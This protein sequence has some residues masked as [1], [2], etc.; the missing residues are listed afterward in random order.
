[1]NFVEFD[2]DE[3]IT[4]LVAGQDRVAIATK[5]KRI[6]LIN[7]K[8][9]E[10]ISCDIGHYYGGRSS[11]IKIFKIFLDPTGKFLLISVTS[12]ADNQP[13]ENLLFIKQLQ[14]LQRLKNHL[15]SAVAWNYTR[16]ASQ[17]LSTGTIL[18]G[19]SKGLVLQTEF[20]QSDE[21]KFF[22]LKTGP[23]HY[24]KE[25]FD[26]EGCAITGIAYYQI[27]NNNLA[28]ERSFVILLSTSNRLYRM[29][30][31]VSANVDP[32]PLHL[33]FSR[34]ATNYKDVPGRFMVSKL[35]LH[36]PSNS[37]P[38]RFG[39]LTEPGI[40]TSELHD[41]LAACRSSFES[42]EDINIIPY[43][44]PEDD[45]LM[46][47][48]SSIPSA[49]SPQF[50][51]IGT[52]DDK[53][54]TI[55]VTNFHVIILRP[56]DFRAICI[57]NNLEVFRYK[58]DRAHCGFAQG[59][60][61]DPFKNIIYVYFEKK[62]L[63]Y[64]MP[65]ENKNVWRIFLD[66][67]RFDLAKKYS[68]G[69]ATNY[70]RVICE[71]A[72]HHFNLKSY[73]KSAEMFAR[74][75]KPFE[76]VALLFMDAKCYKALRKYLMFRLDCFEEGSTQ[77]TLT[78]FWLFELIVSSIAI[79]ESEKE[80]AGELEEFLCELD[81]LLDCKQFVDCMKRRPKL[82]Y[83]VIQNY[84]NFKIYKRVAALIGDHEHL[85]LAHMYAKEFDEVLKILRDLKKADLFYAH[86]HL[87][88][89]YKPRELVDA[90]IAQPDIDPSKLIP[91]LIQ[92]NPYHNKCCE[93]IRYLEY[94]V[95]NL[96]T[97]YKLIHNTLFDLYARYRD[98]ES[99]IEYLKS[100]VGPDGSQIRYLDLQACLRVC[101]ELKLSKTCV[102]IYSYM[103]LYDVAVDMALGFDV[104]L[105]KSMVKQVE[106]EDHQKKLWLDVAKKVLS[107]KD[108]TIEMATALL[109]ES[110][111]LL[112]EDVLKYFPNLKRID[113]IQKHLHHSLQIK[114]DELISIRDGTYEIIANRIK[115]EIKAFKKKYSI[116]SCGQP[117][118]LCSNNIM[119]RPFYVFPCGHL[120]HHDC[121]IKEIILIDPKYHDIENKLKRLAIDPDKEKVMNDLFEITKKEC[122]HCGS[123]LLQYIDTPAPIK[124]YQQGISSTSRN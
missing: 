49:M 45:I 74:S 4:H 52:L 39:W 80:K 65:N 82:F 64:R 51:S 83:G 17:L 20:T 71:E 61:K 108:A 25:I 15:I 19:T 58:F 120:F 5:D 92:E 69:D 3:S 9:N 85:I 6:S 24:V 1:M 109:D 103:G 86:G 84:A 57:L 90:L 88:M 102:L 26:V 55:I 118:D 89:K 8:T 27:N 121:I 94:C 34:N 76:D 114:R 43:N 93:T 77:L 38:T 23:G 46:P 40:M 110:K 59:M 28:T 12:A 115:G 35:D 47:S 100:E 33:I 73:E 75:K 22:P 50:G 97:D 63:K 123:F 113:A 14:S 101:I 66:Q 78:L 99:L 13:Y 18:L 62:I 91:V 7:T 119:A 48:S 31:N 96:H 107:E 124:T 56:V 53:P 79:L 41:Q 60:S 68:S 32:P 67:K 106:S 122:I 2:P 104:E 112:I 70:D 72:L 37:L 111:L 81:Q 36:Y 98:E 21:T 10:Q 42:N 87:L 54:I 29:V 30:G 16:S 117:C 44:S 11:Q 105:A 95:H 116:I